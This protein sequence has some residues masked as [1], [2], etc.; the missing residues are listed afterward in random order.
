VV[1]IGIE[2]S[3]SALL[4]AACDEF[5]FYERLEGVDLTRPRRAT[6]RPRR[7]PTVV[8]ETTDD[9]VTE[10]PAV[11]G[12]DD[13]DLGRLVTRTLSGLERS[14]S[15]PVL[16]SML[17]R[18]ILRKDPTFNEANFGFRG[19]GELLRNLAQR[20]VLELAAGSASGDPEV[21][22]PTTAGDE[23]PAFELLRSTVDRMHRR[24]APVYL[25]GLKTQLRRSEP[26][27]SEKRFG[28][29]GFLQ[30]VKAARARGIV[31]MEW[32]P[33]A[34]DYVLRAVAPGTV[35]GDGVAPPPNGERAPA[36]PEPAPEPAAKPA[37]KAAKEPA[38]RRGR[39]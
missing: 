11:P 5:L 38:K 15:G 26:D 1:G 20:G 2:A 29:G 32:D 12:S 39:R 10:E 19:F 13:V 34:D 7:E 35:L 17:K 28:Y 18:A 24:A 36:V 3:T 21:L 16:A 27:F 23:E 33:E 4:P 31:E 6:R 8:V 37:S 22:F 9:V 14:S 30:F 25:S